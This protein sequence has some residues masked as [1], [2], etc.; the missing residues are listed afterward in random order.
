MLPMNNSYGVSTFFCH[1]GTSEC[2]NNYHLHPLCSLNKLSD[3]E[4]SFCHF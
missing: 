1:T 2:E 3:N 4:K